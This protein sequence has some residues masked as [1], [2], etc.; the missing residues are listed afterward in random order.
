MDL[1][2]GTTGVDS[3]G[4]YGL[5]LWKEGRIP[6]KWGDYED[7]AVFL[8]WNNDK[9]S[10]PG[11]Y[12]IYLE[13]S[14][15]ANPGSSLA[16]TFLAADAQM[17]PGERY[18]EWGGGEDPVEPEEDPV[19]PEEDAEPLDFA[20]VLTD[21][22]G[23]E[24]RARLGDFHKLQPAIKPEVF[25]S[26]LFWEDAESE[27]VLQYVVLPLDKILNPEGKGI[28]AGAIAAISF[29]FDAEQKGTILVDQLGF[30]CG[31]GPAITRH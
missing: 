6:K 12:T 30:T 24:Y 20:L 31:T 25:K 16:L 15:A 3:I 17:D 29:V 21:T 13:P 8:G 22:G 10:I 19:E 14:Y 23:M 5:A 7:N 9:D 11:S 4:A 27:V 1:S 28:S 2:T 18:K 26:R